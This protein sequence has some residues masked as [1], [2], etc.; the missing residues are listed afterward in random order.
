MVPMTV[1]PRCFDHWQRIMPTPPAA[2]W[3]RMVSPDFGR[4]MR[5]MISDAVKPFTI[6]AAACWSEMASGSLIRR[7]AG[8]LRACA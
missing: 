1:A 4:K 3:I 2:V 8:T 5:L 6:I 7:S